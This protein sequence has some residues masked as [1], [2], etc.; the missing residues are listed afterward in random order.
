[1][2]GLFKLEHVRRDDMSV[3]GEAVMP[4][5]SADDP[6]MH[7]EAISGLLRLSSLGQ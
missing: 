1:M 2:R 7:I 3:L 6:M 5:T 4:A